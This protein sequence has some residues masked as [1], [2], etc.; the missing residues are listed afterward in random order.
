MAEVI[1]KE[2][3][4]LY[5]EEGVI[6]DMHNQRYRTLFSDEKYSLRW[7]REAAGIIGEYDRDD[8]DHADTIYLIERHPRTNELVASVRFC[9]TTRPHLMSDVFSDHCAF[10][11]VQTGPRIWECSRLVY[12]RS[13]MDKEVMF[14]YVRPRLRLAIV[15]FCIESGFIEE[16]VHVVPENLYTQTLEIYPDTMMLGPV[17]QGDDGHGYV[18]AKS[19]MNERARQIMRAALPQEYNALI[20]RLPGEPERVGLGDHF[21]RI[22]A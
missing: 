16:I 14:G 20:Y 4:Q 1:T 18:A 13:R 10:T 21:S 5:A 7:D 15:E 22:A 9:P 8:Y 17:I 2:N 12:D 3:Y 11:G 6:D 19:R